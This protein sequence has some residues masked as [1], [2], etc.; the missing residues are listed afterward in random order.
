M[1]GPSAQ[2]EAFADATSEIWC[3]QGWEDK[4]AAGFTCGSATNGD[5]GST[6]Q[7]FVTLA[8]Q[9]GMVWFGLAL[10]RPMGTRIEV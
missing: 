9:R 8:N 7:Y 5:Q 1:G 6:L 10:V 4:I 3:K 2:F